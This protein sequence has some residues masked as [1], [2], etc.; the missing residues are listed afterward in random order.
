MNVIIHSEI[1]DKLNTFLKHGKVPN[2]IFHGPHASGKK[3][4][5][6]TFI[7]DI[8]N[9][10]QSLIQDHVID[11][12]CAQGKGIKF[13]REELKF[14][15]RIN[16]DRKDNSFFKTIILQNADNLTIDAQSALRRCIELFSHSTRFFIIVQNKY[17]LLKPIL[18]RF[19]E[20]YVPLPIIEGKKISIYE[21]FLNERYNVQKEQTK[22]LQ[23]L[24]KLIYDNYPKKNLFWITNNLYEK[25]FSGLDIIDLFENISESELKISTSKKYELLLY[26]Q[27]IK[28]EFRS[29]KLLMVKLLNY[30][31]IR[32][33]A[34]LENITIM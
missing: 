13:V 34:P 12:N 24:K 17:R 27:H 23:K 9:N 26:F 14:F 6:Y 20:I 2:I 7:D 29:E 5:L 30:I 25:G 16:I 32:S 21:W 11:V 15:A 10:D 31:L 4:V 18:S 3:H 8:Y 19:C 22:H 33:S 28:K 1:K